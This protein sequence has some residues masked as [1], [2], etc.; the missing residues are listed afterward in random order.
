MHKSLAILTL[1]VSTA[2][3]SHASIARTEERNVVQEGGALVHFLDTGAIK[4]G[5]PTPDQLKS[6]AYAL[7]DLER[8]RFRTQLSQTS[9][10]R[11]YHVKLLYEFAVAAEQS[12]RR[13]H[14][15]SRWAHI[16]QEADSDAPAELALMLHELDI[17]APRRDDESL[18]C[19]RAGVELI[20]T[21]AVTINYL[22]CGTWSNG[23]G[24]EPDE[25]KDLSSLLQGQ[26]GKDE[27][28]RKF[29]DAAEQQ[30]RT[31]ARA[32]AFAA[33][34][35]RTDSITHRDMVLAAL[36]GD[37]LSAKA[38][39]A[40]V[41][42]SEAPWLIEGRWAWSSIAA[43][44]AA[45]TSPFP[46]ETKDRE[47]DR[48]AQRTSAYALAAEQWLHDVEEFMLGPGHMIEDRPMEAWDGP[49]ALLLLHQGPSA[50]SDDATASRD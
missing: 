48:A 34:S 33:S 46:W 14:G 41:G 42:L 25:V 47:C 44:A 29:V 22:R 35:A 23:R 12:A 39:Q 40:R 3:A 15:V 50:A 21:G 13:V 32:L 2:C 8:R 4:W 43:C 27:T 5:D 38:A 31:L 1:L 9:D 7:P 18:A 45:R 16:L 36:Y 28:L 49:S 30:G 6:S 17:R 24:I 10:E 19:A 11:F 37:V 20:R 26:A